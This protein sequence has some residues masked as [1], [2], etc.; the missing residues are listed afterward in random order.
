ME[1]NNPSFEDRQD[2]NS[3]SESVQR[4]KVQDE[5]EGKHLGSLRA[6]IIALTSADLVFADKALATYGVLM[7]IT[8]RPYVLCL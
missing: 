1:P 4:K 7:M 5:Q 8:G 2:G 6:V 3:S